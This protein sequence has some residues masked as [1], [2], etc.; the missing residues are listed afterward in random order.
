VQQITDDRTA[1]HADHPAV[2]AAR[3]AEAHVVGSGQHPSLGRCRFV[4]AHRERPPVLRYPV[5][6]GRAGRC[7]AGETGDVAGHHD[8]LGAA[9]MCQVDG[10][11][12][13]PQ[14]VLDR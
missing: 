13:V 7:P 11:A 4:G 1:D 6:H 10:P 9:G 8:G 14:R 3:R 12:G 5:G 2:G